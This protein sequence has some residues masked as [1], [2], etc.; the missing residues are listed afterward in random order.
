MYGFQVLVKTEISQKEGLDLRENRFFVQG[1]GG[2]K[3]THN[4]GRLANEPHLAV[5]NFL[6]AL[7]KI[8]SMIEK[9]QKEIAVI[10]KDLPVLKEVVSKEWTKE[11]TLN[12]LKNELTSIDRKIQLSIAP[13]KEEVKE[14]EK[15]KEKRKENKR[16]VKI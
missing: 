15:G 2:I 3:Y 9:Q 16:V 1:E 5:T 8:P 11:N 13:V 4:N 10:E 6:N 7:E 14:N 12:E